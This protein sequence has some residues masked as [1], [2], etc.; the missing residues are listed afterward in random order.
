MWS[1]AARAD[2]DKTVLSITENGYGKRTPVEEY[3]ITNR[4][5]IGIRNYMV[6][7]KTGPRGGHQGGGRH[8]GP[9]AGDGRRAS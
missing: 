3:R 7:D 6:T 9:A 4:G 5:G 2:A 8:R 1:G